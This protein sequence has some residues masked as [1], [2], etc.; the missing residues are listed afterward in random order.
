[1][2]KLNLKY[3][4]PSLISS[5]TAIALIILLDAIAAPKV[6]NCIPIALL[7]AGPVYDFI[8]IWKEVKKKFGF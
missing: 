2:K 6:L 5:L 1:M 3:G 8:S 4:L 7:V